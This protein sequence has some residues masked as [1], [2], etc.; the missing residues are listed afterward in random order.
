MSTYATADYF[1]A[2]GLDF[3]EGRTFM[4]DEHRRPP[5]VVVVNQDFVKR[6]FGEKPLGRVVT[7]TTVGHAGE[8]ASVDAMVVGVIADPPGR[9]IFSRLPNVFFPAPDGPRFA[10]DLAVRFEGDAKG[11]ASAIRTIVSGL[12]PRLPLDQFRTGEELRRLRNSRQYTLTQVVS[13]LGVLSLVLAAAGL[14]GVVS[15]MVT[16]RQKEIGIRMALGA[17]SSSVLRLVLRQSIVPVLGGCI[18]G[19]L[20]AAVIAKVTRAQLYGVSPMDPF[21][22]GGATLLLVLVMIAASLVPA[23][24]A[25]RVDPV[26]VLRRE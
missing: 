12:E 23:R 2:M 25:S 16:L 15:Y 13:L 3:V 22:F 24:R 1:E 4:R 11:M 10:L 6:A 18:L 21:A 26:D 19:A 8:R 7:L 9:P 20:G 14:Y 17:G 5:R